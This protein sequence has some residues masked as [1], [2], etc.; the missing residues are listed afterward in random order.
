MD[1]AIPHTLGL[2]LV[3]QI[4][5][6][7]KEAL[8]SFEE[9]FIW[10]N[11]ILETAKIAFQ[12]SE[13]QT[14]PKTPSAKKRKGKKRKSDVPSFIRRSSIFPKTADQSLNDSYNAENVPPPRSN[15][16][17]A[18]RNLRSRQKADTN[19]GIS[20]CNTSVLRTRNQRNASARNN[21]YT[22]PEL[23]P[24]KEIPESP[25]QKLQE[26]QPP[27]FDEPKE[28]TAQTKM[29][30]S[31]DLVTKETKQSSPV[32][33]KILSPTEMEASPHQS[34]IP[35]PAKP[36]E[37]SEVSATNS[38]PSECR[39]N[40]N[41]F[42]I[43]TPSEA[44]SALS[45]PVIS[46][47]AKIP[48]SDKPEAM[49]TDSGVTSDDKEQEKLHSEN[50]EQS[51]A[52]TSSEADTEPDTGRPSSSSPLSGEEMN[53]PPRTRTRTRKQQ[54]SMPVVQLPA[55]CKESISSTTS[56]ESNEAPTRMTRSRMRTKQ[57]ATTKPALVPV[58]ANP[59]SETCDSAMTED[60]PEEPRTRTRTRLQKRKSDDLEG[61][62]DSD[63]KRQCTE[64]KPA[65]E[66]KRC[67]SRLSGKKSAAKESPEDADAENSD[68][69]DADVTRTETWTAPSNLKTPSNMSSSRSFLTMNSSYL[70]ANRTPSQKSYTLYKYIQ[71]NNSFT[72]SAQ[73][74]GTQSRLNLLSGLGNIKSLLKRNQTPIKGTPKIGNNQEYIEQR[75]REF[76]EKRK[77]EQ[78]RLM[79]REELQKMKMEERKRKREERMRKVAESRQ[80]RETKEQEL[81]DKKNKKLEEKLSVTDRLRE[82]KLREER[83]KLRLRL[84]KQ[85]EAEER[86]NQEDEERAKKLR[87]QEEEN[88]R[89]QAMLQRKK[90][91]E[92]Q[93]RL[94]KLAEEKRKLEE[95][96]ERMLEAE[97]EKQNE[98]ERRRKFEEERERER[99]RLKEERE[100]EANRIRA[101]REQAQRE[102][103]RELEQERL[104]YEQQEAEKKELRDQYIAKILNP[105]S[106]VNSVAVAPLLSS[107][108]AYQKEVA[109]PVGEN[110]SLNTSNKAT[111]NHDSYQMTPKRGSYNNYDITELKSDDSTDEEDGPRKPIPKWAQGP[112]LKISLLKQFYNPPNL[113]EIF[114]PIE[115]PDLNEL[116]VKKKSRF[117]RR[118]SS[119]VWDSPMLK[120]HIP[121]FN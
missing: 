58:A 117:N 23:S 10:L 106:T 15:A 52:K 88:Q 73:K 107:S 42:V 5:Y 80:L 39:V 64:S 33:A 29:D 114:L 85:Q 72:G 49:D 119:A 21:T 25:V 48:T 69:D 104:K 100:K 108:S 78:E 38:N 101:E 12:T 45:L 120:S 60:K 81:K 95:Q 109:K 112:E 18:T 77:K 98:L 13:I 2:D 36:V 46:S 41:S 121:V 103:L 26:E 3:K 74:S 102:K 40:N 89:H 67:S 90:E 4:E 20:T 19:A 31:E 47:P 24:T 37:N 91:Y 75:K 111:S 54:Q 7:T 118:T 70:S 115:L 99:L 55:P 44:E 87:K 56:A 57:P 86:R 16:T 66:E 93:E 30:V 83:E 71:Q 63:T 62:A 1:K 110:T 22:E 51:E 61:K 97:K 76:E 105:P 59:S 32:V 92:E 96:R 79:K 53:Q 28:D 116:F 113:D 17:R 94:R 8:E 68:L 82:E 35:S 34:V 27:Q 11:E 9:D 14:L 43:E 65:N 84:K 50:G 6:F